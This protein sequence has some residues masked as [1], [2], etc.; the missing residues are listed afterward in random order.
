[1]NR[2]LVS[3]AGF[4][5]FQEMEGNDRQKRRWERARKDAYEGSFMHFARI[6]IA[7]GNPK[8]QGFEVRPIKPQYK[9]NGLK[10]SPGMV[11]NQQEVTIDS[12]LQPHHYFIKTDDGRF[13]FLFEDKIEIS[14]SKKRPDY[15]YSVGPMNRREAIRISTLSL[16]QIP[17]ELDVTGTF[18]NPLAAIFGGYWGWEKIGNMLPLDYQA[19]AED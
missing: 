12:L 11:L 17:A 16:Q 10:P 7:G 3:Y 13:F 18:S 9:V 1:M 8:E 15:Y 4:P 19:E 2:G 5:F 6:L 14:Y